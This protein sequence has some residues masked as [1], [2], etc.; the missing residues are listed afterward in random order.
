MKRTSAAVKQT[1]LENFVPESQRQT[2]TAMP[3]TFSQIFNAT[4]RPYGTDERGDDAR[5]LLHY[6]D[7]S[8]DWYIIERD[9]LN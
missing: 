1:I 2:L 6:F 7:G 4:P 3:R 9:D 5:A 8:S